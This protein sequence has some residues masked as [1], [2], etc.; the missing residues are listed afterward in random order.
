MASAAR[1]LEEDPLL[2]LDDVLV[3]HPFGDSRYI[4]ERLHAAYERRLRSLAVD[5][6]PA[7]ALLDALEPAEPAQRYRLFGDTIVR[8]AI[9]HA[10]AQLAT[11]ERY[12]LPLDRCAEI[13]DGAARALRLGRTPLASELR[14]HLAGDPGMALIWDPDRED[15]L[16][17]KA[18]R[19]VFEG[20]YENA[21]SCAATPEDLDMLDRAVSLLSHLLPRSSAGALAH[22]HI[23]VLFPAEGAWA[24]RMSSSEFRISGTI[25]LSRS[26]LFS[27]WTAAEH[28]LHE[29]LHQQL[30]D[31]R[32][33]HLLLDPAFARADAPLVHSPWNKPDASRGNYWDVHRALAAFHVYVHLALMARL[34]ERLG[35]GLPEFGPVTMVGKRTASARAHYLLTQLRSVGWDELG[36][37]GKRLVD[38]FASILAA[39]DD[40]PPA[41][42]ARVHL[43]LD[44]YWREAME[45]EVFLNRSDDET[46]RARLPSLMEEEIERTRAVLASLG[47]DPRRFDAT[48]SALPRDD[49][50]IHFRR[51]RTLV[52]ETILNLCSRD[53]LLAESLEPDRLVATMVEDSSKVLCTLLDP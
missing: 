27:P 22:T 38:W 11:K 26:I 37:A 52:A 50:P 12:G 32:A 36:P 30:Y 4:T 24:T 23:I 2:C 10:Q 3:E 28:L 34:A 5:L 16:F 49:L 7:Q 13:L 8:C 53:L 43:L 1:V 33:G 48:L 9:Q 15:D 14:H 42:Q 31:I 47:E 45:V 51:V 19:E 21:G 25:F 29:S 17:R 41:P 46:I 44:R 40:R 35:P 18:Y 6:A 39:V 20:N